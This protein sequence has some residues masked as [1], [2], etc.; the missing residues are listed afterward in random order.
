[1]TR[2]RTGT[3]PGGEIDFVVQ[4][5]AQAAH[6]QVAAT[7]RPAETLAREL[8]PLQAMRDHHPKVLLS[9][10]PD[11]PTTHN[12]IRQWYAV[13]WLRGQVG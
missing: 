11:P 5:G 12:G 10:D 7:V 3:S 1:L 2:L 9:L 4:Q 6:Y 13:D 8:A